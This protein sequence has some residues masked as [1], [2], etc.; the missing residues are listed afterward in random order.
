MLS[1]NVDRWLRCR[2]Q[3]PGQNAFA[4]LM[5]QARQSKTA[6]GDVEKAQEPTDALSMLMQQARGAQVSSTAEPSCR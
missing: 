1:S 3:G 5:K 2:Q 4:V 6:T